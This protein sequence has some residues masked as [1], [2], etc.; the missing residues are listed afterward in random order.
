MHGQWILG[1]PISRLIYYTDFLK[2][3]Y[4][5]DIGKKDVILQKKTHLFKILKM[6]VIQKNCLQI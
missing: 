5:L 1:Q 3:N 6:S 2:K 4:Q